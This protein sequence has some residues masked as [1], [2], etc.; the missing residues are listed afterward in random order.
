MLNS[1]ILTQNK[2][3]FIYEICLSVYML[4]LYVYMLS[5]RKII[6]DSFL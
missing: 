2:S 6:L 4:S 5:Y 1:T 3:D